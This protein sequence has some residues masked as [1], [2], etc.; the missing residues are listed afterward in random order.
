MQMEQR[1]HLWT[2]FSY[3][4][5]SGYREKVLRALA[6]T[7]KLPHQL[8]KDTQ[9]RLGHVSRALTEL[10]RRQL[11]VCL[12]PEVKARGRLYTLTS[13]GS[14][15]ARRINGPS[16]FP[17]LPGSRTP[18]FS[19][20]VPKIRAETVLRVVRY[21]Q[22]R[23][24]GEAAAAILGAWSVDPTQLT[25]DSWIPVDACA[26]FLDLIERRLGDGSYGFI[27]RLFLDAVATFPTIREQLGKAI[28]LNTLAKRAPTVYAREW[29]YGRMEVLTAPHRNAMRHYDW[30]PT[31]AMCAMFHGIYEGILKARH[32]RG[33]VTKTQ[34][35]RNGDPCC[36]YLVEW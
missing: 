6:E 1:S 5:S 33:K 22:Q 10:S 4:V 20:F 24:Q 17:R 3:V 11:A 35:I 30:L 31:P 36:E 32:V 19:D 2:D 29:N 16:R 28:P 23:H 15:L 13:D 14:A 9:L 7:P 18:D 21:L 34:C 25:D 12:T 27:R 26:D 8:A